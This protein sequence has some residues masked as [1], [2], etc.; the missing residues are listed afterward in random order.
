[1]FMSNF[2]PYKLVISYNGTDYSGWQ[3][4]SLEYQTIQG[5]IEKA[6]LK[7]LKHRDFSFYGSSRT[8]TGVHAR[9]QVALLKSKDPIDEERFV[10]QINLQL[11]LSIRILSFTEACLEFNPQTNL[12]SKEYH[13]YFSSNQISAQNIPFVLEL[14]D[15][16]DIELMNKACEILVGSHCFSNF[17]TEKL[18]SKNTKREIFKCEILEENLSF[19]NESVY[20]FKIEGSGFLKYMVRYVFAHLIKIGLGELTLE[21][22]HRILLNQS[23]SGVKKAPAKGLHLFRINY[24]GK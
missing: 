5:E 20:V 6:I 12:A 23:D 13:Y 9:G 18:S 7:I 19:Q 21:S 24:T 4:Q 2:Y 16:V 22:F 10:F 8:D 14:K 1:M 17:T 15:E 3:R 11:P